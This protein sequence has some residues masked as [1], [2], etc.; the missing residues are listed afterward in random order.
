M[1]AAGFLLALLLVQRHALAACDPPPPYDPSDIFKEYPRDQILSAPEVIVEGVVE[2]YR[3]LRYAPPVAVMRIDKVW[4]GTATP[5]VV[6][7]LQMFFSSEWILDRWDCGIR[8]PVG[9]RIRLGASILSK[10]GDQVAEDSGLDANTYVLGG[11]NLFYIPL[12]DPELDRKLAAYQ[13]KTDQLQ[14]SAS[15]GG[16][17]SKLAFAA[18]LLAN[19][20]EHRALEAYDGLLRD[21]P[22][23]LDLLLVVAVARSQAR[24]D[25]EPDAT[26]A[27]VGAKAPKTE[28]W[29]S[30]IARARLAATGL[31]TAEGKDWSDLKRIHTKCYSEHANFDNAVF[32][33]AELPEC[34]FR[35]SS[36]RNASFRGTDLTG[37]YFQNADLTGA[38]YDCK[39]R[40]PDDLDP[41]AAGMINVEGECHAP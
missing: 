11:Y 4:K 33:R 19:N 25:G 15:N 5:R 17:Q 2:A 22:N 32:D 27:V 1:W 40:L 26:L 36:F 29:R 12:K 31:L 9:E 18:H 23:D 41:K 30:K 21:S 10:H 38:K 28:K 37:S 3:P 16:M 35:Y 14:Q 34:A 7:E 8:A 13:N 6:V 24:V 20:E 39:S